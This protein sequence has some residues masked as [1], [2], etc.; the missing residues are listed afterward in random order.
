M[1]SR[2][3]SWML[4]SDAWGQDAVAPGKCP[5]AHNLGSCRSVSGGGIS[6]ECAGGAEATRPQFDRRR[7][8][9]R[10]GAIVVDGK[11]CQAAEA[12]RAAALAASSN[13]AEISRMLMT[14]IRL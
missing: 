8:A 9:A 10:A 6:A 7:R 13:A 3:V 14:P 2:V 11:L 4:V 1:V 5:P 12:G